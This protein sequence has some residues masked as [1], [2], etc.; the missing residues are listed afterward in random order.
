M[1]VSSPNVG[2]LPTIR[3]QAIPNRSGWGFN[4]ILLAV[5]NCGGQFLSVASDALRKVA[6]PTALPKKINVYAAA[7]VEAFFDASDQFP[8]D[9]VASEGDVFFDVSSEQSKYFDSKKL[10][11]V[12]Q[13]DDGA[14]L[15]I[16]EQFA[17]GE[18]V[19]VQANRSNSRVH[20]EA[21]HSDDQGLGES[22]NSQAT[23]NDGL[24]AED[25]NVADSSHTVLPAIQPDKGTCN[26]LIG[27]KK[28]LRQQKRNEKAGPTHTK[29]MNDA[30]S[31]K[32][33]QAKKL[34]KFEKD[35]AQKAVAERAAQKAIVE[36][37]RTEKANLAQEQ[38]RLMDL[39]AAPQFVEKAVLALNASTG[40]N[41]TVDGMTF[42]GDFLKHLIGDK[43]KRS[44]NNHDIDR[45]GKLKGAHQID[46]A[47][48]LLGNKIIS[49][50]QLAD[51]IDDIRYD[52]LNGDP[53][54][55]KKTVFSPEK[56]ETVVKGAVRA[57]QRAW[58]GALGSPSG[59][60]EVDGLRF[61]V[62]I[63]DQRGVRYIA[64]VYPDGAAVAIER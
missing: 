21:L 5:R 34:K 20:H 40:S 51:G 19:P 23:Q 24:L 45:E 10:N 52:S 57:A 30:E 33:E 18:M 9:V 50:G 12:Q 48:T 63:Q 25:E 3:Q 37:Q 28:L 59:H 31:R 55:H 1:R 42:R 49:Y 38:E 17:D 14:T 54:I 7:D 35:E 41:V 60:V 8:K 43:R 11:C 58:D 61:F 2:Q 15:P 36:R 4:Q 16:K 47:R 46:V 22:L 56:Q 29:I 27:D 32:A 6:T 62:A 26:L 64:T 44:I 13:E 39:R 53:V